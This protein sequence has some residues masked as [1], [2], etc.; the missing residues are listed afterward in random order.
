MYFPAAIEVGR[1]GG[2]IIFLQELYVYWISG[3][4]TAIRMVSPFDLK[5]I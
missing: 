2:Q 4:S 1:P 3:M 5:I